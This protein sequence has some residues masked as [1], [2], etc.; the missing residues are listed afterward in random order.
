M[1]T[2]CIVFSELWFVESPHG[3]RF[4]ATCII[5]LYVK[6]AGSNIIFESTLVK[7]YSAK[8]GSTSLQDFHKNSARLLNW[9]A[10][11][12]IVII[13]DFRDRVYEQA[14]W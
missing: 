9:Q 5:G 12:I 2:R 6:F 13:L 10:G 7:Q 1:T 8:N 3:Y 11:N 14:L 4:S